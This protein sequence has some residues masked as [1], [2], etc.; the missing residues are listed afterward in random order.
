ME[1]LSDGAIRKE[2]P[3]T[4]KVWQTTAIVCMMLAIAIIVHVAFSVLLMALSGI[5]IAVYFHGLAGIIQRRLKLTRK[6]SLITS[7][8][9]TVILLGIL[10][11]FIGSKIQEQSTELRTAIP[12]TIRTIKEKLSQTT[13]G[14]KVVEYLDG[15]KSQKLLETATSLLNTGFGVMAEL[16]IIVF[17]GMYFTVNPNLYRNGILYLFPNRRKDCGRMILSRINNVLKGWLK[18]ILISMLLITMLIAVSLTIV[19]LPVTMVLGL[20]TGL[21]ELVPNFG[22]ILAMIPG[23][24]LAW[25]ISTKTAILVAFVYIACQTI[26]ESIVAPLLQKKII[27]MP[28]ALTLISQ[29]I[30]GILQGLMGI[31][32]AVPLLAILIIVVDELYVKKDNK[33]LNSQSV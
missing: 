20:I 14:Q 24:L 18:C 29:L 22:P 9:G 10:I 25:T 23:V 5:L 7:V 30:M 12:M 6:I 21:L 8:G 2:L 32:L 1:Q 26:V 31:I 13:T 11:G 15:N 16:Y 19:G 27:H 28:P 3:H 4:V 17:L 33:V